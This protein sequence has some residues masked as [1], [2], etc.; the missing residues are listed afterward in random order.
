[1]WHTE[2]SKTT[3]ATKEQIWKIWSDVNNWH[4]WDED[5][6]Y[7]NL[8]GDFIL[9]TKGSVKSKG[10]PKN[11]F[12]I[13]ECE[14]YSCFTNRTTLPLCKIDF[15]HILTQTSDGLMV[16]HRIEMKGMLS[17][18]F[19]KIIGVAINKGVSQSVQ[20]LIKLA[21]NEK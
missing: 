3:K 17:F 4:I 10:A 18:L 16:T 14:K 5:L 21:E 19:S 1:M 9:Y 8:D 15:M 12:V 20:N 13:I 6:E 2:I 11:K 7:A